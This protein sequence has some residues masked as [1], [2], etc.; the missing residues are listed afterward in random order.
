MLTRSQPLKMEKV[1]H[2]RKGSPVASKEV[3][4][5]P[6]L[7]LI[8]PYTPPDDDSDFEVMNWSP[9]KVARDGLVK[10]ESSAK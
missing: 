1:P 2:V 5:S 10:A 6:T 8:K 9:C 7:N 3:N 4:G